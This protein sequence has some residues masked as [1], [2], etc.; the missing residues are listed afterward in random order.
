MKFMLFPI[1]AL[2][3]SFV[4]TTSTYAEQAALFSMRS[5]SFSDRNTIPA[6]YTCDGGDRS[7]ELAW[8]GAP[9]KT[10][11]YVLICV[12]PDAP[13]G[14]FYHWVLYNIPRSVSEIPAGAGAAPG[15]ELGR[16][17]WGRA[18][19]NGPCP[20]PSSIHRYHFTLYALDIRLPLARGADAQTVLN[21]MQGH[22]LGQTLI[23]GVFG[24]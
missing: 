19:Y 22:V 21:A 18:Q 2:S 1:L 4:I 10:V 23:L 16:N 6:L 14:A 5:S 9:P 13:T 12:D 7:P 3:T 11:S 17:S 24:H 20:P 15:A 8:Q